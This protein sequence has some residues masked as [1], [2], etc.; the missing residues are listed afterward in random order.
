[1]MDVEPL[2]RRFVW[3]D[4]EM[5][6]CDL[7][8]I[9]SPNSPALL[10]FSPGSDVIIGSGG[11]GVRATGPVFGASMVD[12]N[13]GSLVIQAAVRAG[14][15]D[16]SDAHTDDAQV[17]GRHATTKRDAMAESICGDMTGDVSEIK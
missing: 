10:L 17:D 16:L 14:E 8:T 3:G 1:M 15:E 6:V 4:T 7:S 2:F 11:D 13:S 9:G 5:E 12:I